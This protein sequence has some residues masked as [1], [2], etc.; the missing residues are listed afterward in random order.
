MNVFGYVVW[1]E[2]DGGVRNRYLVARSRDSYDSVVL[3][4]C[5]NVLPVLPH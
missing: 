4:E 5:R 1:C 2:E 3:L